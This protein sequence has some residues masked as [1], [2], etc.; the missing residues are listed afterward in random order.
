MIHMRKGTLIHLPRA[1]LTMVMPCMLLRWEGEELA[2]QST[3]CPL[4]STPTTWLR[5]RLMH[6]PT[7]AA[8]EG[9]GEGLGA[10]DSCFPGEHGGCGGGAG[11]EG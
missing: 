9:E 7:L 6:L 3:T 8:P 2:P 5:L 1:A 10:G 4:T 11:E